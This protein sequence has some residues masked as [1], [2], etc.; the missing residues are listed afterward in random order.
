MILRFRT[1]RSEQTVQTQIRLQADQGVHCLP[2]L[3]HLLDTLLFGI[4]FLFE[5]REITSNFSDIRK[6]RNFTLIHVLADT[7]ARQR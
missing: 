2:F 6:F 5:F 3:L 7:A 1:D 4:T